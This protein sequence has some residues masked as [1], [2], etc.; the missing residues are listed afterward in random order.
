M[1]YKTS[2]YA[3]KERLE[4][5]GHTVIGLTSVPFSSVVTYEFDFDVKHEPD[6]KAEPA[7]EPEKPRRG[8]PNWRKQK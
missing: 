3:E 7:I 6:V 1:G 5:E 2:D 4:Q 8:N